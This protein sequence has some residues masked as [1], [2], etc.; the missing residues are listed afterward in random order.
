MIFLANIF[1][2][3]KL[4]R[5]LNRNKNII[6]GYFYISFPRSAESLDTNGSD[7]KSESQS[8]DASESSASLSLDDDETESE[9][10]SDSG[11]GSIV[12]RIR[13]RRSTV[14]QGSLSLNSASS[15]SSGG[16]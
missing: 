11:G 9:E 6:V 14:V 15:S 1:N 2:L 10:S 8:D 12:E 4:L 3:S 13:L 7:S 5:L 16:R